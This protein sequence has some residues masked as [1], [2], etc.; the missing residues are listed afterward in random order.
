M[1][2][3][4]AE[5]DIIQATVRLVGISPRL[6]IFLVM[7]TFLL[8]VVTGARVKNVLC[9]GTRYRRGSAGFQGDGVRVSP[10]RSWVLATGCNK[11]GSLFVERDANT[12]RL[13]QA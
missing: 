13:I 9:S 12:M 7:V 3:A 6:E 8:S 1:L 11:N 10:Q 4:Q 2:G 5:A